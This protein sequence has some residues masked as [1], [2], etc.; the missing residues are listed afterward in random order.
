[1]NS[2][3]RIASLVF[4]ASLVSAG[5]AS[6]FALTSGP[7]TPAAEGKVVAKAGPNNN[8]KLVIEVKHLAPPKK[9]NPE[10]KVYVVWVQGAAE[11]GTPQ[12]LGA[13]KVDSNLKGTLETLTPLRDFRLT[14]TVERS[15]M[16]TSP[17][18][19]PVLAA[20]ISLK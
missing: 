1:M 11:N 14:I 3:G 4:V 12:N 19:S 10:G 5:C 8:T 9:V 2:I 6:T 20:R 15:A 13:L 16:L 18:S 17:T 7:Q